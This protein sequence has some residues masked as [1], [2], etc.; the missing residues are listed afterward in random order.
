MILIKDNLYL[1]FK[2]NNI[3]NNKINL[4]FGI[5]PT[6]KSI[7]LGHFYILKNIIFLRKIKK[8]NINIILGT[9]TSYINKKK[10]RKKIIYNN[11]FIYKQI[12]CIFN[13]ISINIYK[14]FFWFKKIKLKF[15][16]SKLLNK[17]IKGNIKNFFYPLCQIFDTI[18]LNSN[19][20]LGGIDQKKI[21]SKYN[22]CQYIM[23]SLLLNNN[24]K[25]IS[26]S[27]NNG[28][29]LLKNKNLLFLNLLNCNKLIDIY[30]KFK[31]L[32]KNYKINNCK[33]N[34]CFAYSICK[35]INLKK[36]NKILN[37][38]INKRF[39]FK[40]IFINK[41]KN[42]L[43]IFKISK[44]NRFSRLLIKNKFIKINNI[45]VKNPFLI[46]KK[47]FYKLKYKSKLFVFLYER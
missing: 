31:G 32:I 42:I 4:K 40:K 27:T 3:L 24:N 46:I 34:I 35:E 43:K 39:I 45:I 30:K 36:S 1:F 8:I 6:N 19:L 12:K 47:G 41:I 11:A 14:N 20:E 17:K 28:G 10:L 16:I 15:F 23:F 26:K 22:N 44:S 37:F 7:H 9:Y 18:V 2:K 21:F 25:K 13:N 5:D 33:K 29:F 38:Y